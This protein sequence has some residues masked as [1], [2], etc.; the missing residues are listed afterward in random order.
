MI[1]VF[2]VLNDFAVRCFASHIIYCSHCSVP[3]LANAIR[4]GR[5]FWFIENVRLAIR[6]AVAAIRSASAL[7]SISRRFFQFL[8]KNKNKLQRTIHL[9]WPIPLHLLTNSIANMPATAVEKHIQTEMPDPSAGRRPFCESKMEIRNV[10]SLNESLSMDW[11]SVFNH[12][13]HRIQQRPH[14]LC[15]PKIALARQR[16]INRNF[17][18]I[19]SFC[20]SCLWRFDCTQINILCFQGNRQ[21]RF[22]PDVVWQLRVHV[23]R[24]R[25]FSNEMTP[26]KRA[27]ALNH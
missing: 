7:P 26:Y 9:W 13:K 1:F 6:F 27:T 20:N 15:P 19:E 25:S 2:I 10:I 8:Q 17:H 4:Q 5:T 11:S 14:Y 23:G 22:H 18:F 16:C 3:A 21:I 12:R 24:C